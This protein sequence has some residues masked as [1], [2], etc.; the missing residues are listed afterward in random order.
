VKAS[1][2]EIKAGLVRAAVE[3]RMRM[4]MEVIGQNKE[5]EPGFVYSGLYM[6][7]KTD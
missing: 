4:S 3:K 1:S 2:Y 6:T 5:K 7:K